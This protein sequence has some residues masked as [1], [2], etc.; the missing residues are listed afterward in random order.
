M[1]STSSGIAPDDYELAISDDEQERPKLGL[2]AFRSLFEGQY[3]ILYE[4]WQLIVQKN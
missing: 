3:N 4:G 2:N 1:A